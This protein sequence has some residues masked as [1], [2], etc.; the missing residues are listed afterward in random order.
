[1]SIDKFKHV[2]LALEPGQ[3]AGQGRS[4]RRLTAQAAL[5]RCTVTGTSRGR[6]SGSRDA[7]V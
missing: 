4:G 3:P 1:M 6:G 7:R 5:R 2:R